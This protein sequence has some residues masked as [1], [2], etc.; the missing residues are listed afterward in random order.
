[1][2]DFLIQERLERLRREQQWEPV[3]LE[4]PLDERFPE[5]PDGSNQDQYKPE[6]DFEIDYEEVA[7]PY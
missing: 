4:L 6:V 7:K 1:M 5:L 3:P 2:L